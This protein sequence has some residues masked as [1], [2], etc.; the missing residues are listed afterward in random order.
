MKL[1]ASVIASLHKISKGFWISRDDGKL[2]CDLKL[3]ERGPVH[4]YVLTQA[5]IDALKSSA[6][7]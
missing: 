1:N 3:A 5:G 2:L 6:V 4:G 7:K